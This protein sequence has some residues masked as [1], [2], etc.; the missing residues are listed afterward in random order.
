MR[1]FQIR[2]LVG[3]AYI[4]VFLNRE[5]GYLLTNPS[6]LG[7]SE[8]FNFASIG[9]YGFQKSSYQ[10]SS[11][12]KIVCDLSFI[13]SNPY[14]LYQTFLANLNRST[15]TVLTYTP[16]STP[17]EAEVYFESISKGELSSPRVLTCQVTISLLTPWYLKTHRNIASTTTS[18]SI[19]NQGHF[20]SGWYYKTT[21]SLTNPSFSCEGSALSIT[22]TVNGLE[23]VSI[24]GRTSVTDGTGNSLLQ[25][26]DITT[27]PF[28]QIPTGTHVLTIPAAV[29]SL[30]TYAYYRS[31]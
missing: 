30:D 15:E 1:K 2:F 27:N 14:S 18:V 13:G 16:T 28:F 25:S 9:N 3:G 21:S 4:T 31:V 26:V 7:M 23:I 10:V 29:A 20:E 19:N 6:G 8:S 17:Y 24:P 22:G 5:T 11:P 12:R